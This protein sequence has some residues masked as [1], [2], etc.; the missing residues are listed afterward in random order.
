MAGRAAEGDS[1]LTRGVRGRACQSSVT[2]EQKVGGLVRPGFRKR[3]NFGACQSRR[4]GQ[5]HVTRRALATRN[6]EVRILESVASEAFGN[7][8]IFHRHADRA[9]LVVAGRAVAD[10]HTVRGSLQRRRA[11]VHLVGE[12]PVAGARAGARC[13]RHRA[14]H[15]PVMTGSTANRLRKNR[16]SGFDYSCMAAGAQREDIRVLAMRKTR[17]IQHPAHLRGSEEPSRRKQRERC[18]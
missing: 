8:R 17:F 15:Y 12:A 6:I 4:F 18:R 16:R 2:A 9:C 7:Y 13:P 11:V 5:L 3:R 1:L 14:L 10:H